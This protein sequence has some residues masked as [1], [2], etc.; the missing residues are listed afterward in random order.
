METQDIVALVLVYAI[1]V[2]SLG[3]SLYL[4]RRGSKID[5]RKVVHIGVGNFVFVWWMFTEGWVML[6][7]F[8][9]PFA[10]LLFFAML[11]GNALSRSKLGEISN[12]GHKTGLFFYAVTI[13]ILVLLCPDHWTAASI[14]VVAMTYGDGF[15]SVIGRRFGKHRI[16]EGK[17][18]EGS[19]G[20]LA[21]TFLAAMAVVLLFGYLASIG[22]Y[23]AGAY[24]GSVPAPVACLV[25][26][27]VA[28]AVEAACSGSYDN[29]AV[30][31]SVTLAMVLL[32][33]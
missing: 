24:N 13:T 33:L 19:L 10:V 15:G 30:P 7:F 16:R 2:A 23:P 29:L 9:I 3:A 31:L 11:K 5:T 1:I 8:T 28:A 6:V 12:Q 27:G 14:G 20:V 32:G 4:E 22:W 25:A 21:T 26:G 18:L 17:S